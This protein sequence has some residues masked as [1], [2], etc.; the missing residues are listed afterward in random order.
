MEIEKTTIAA[1]EKRFQ[2]GDWSA[3]K[4][5]EYFLERIAN[6]DQAGAT[7][8]SVIELN[9]DAL[10]IAAELDA[11]HL[12]HGAKGSLHGIPILIKDSID[13]ADKMMTT[14]GSLAFAG[15]FAEQ[16]AFIVRKLRDAGAVLLGKTNLSEL[17]YS[18]SF[19]GCSGWSSRGGQ[20]R[21]PY[22]LD[23]TPG[24][25]SSGSAV[26]VAANLCM[27]AIGCE[28]DGSIVVPAALNSI[29]GLKPSIGL[30]SRSG[31]IP[32]SFSQDTAGPMARCVSD[33]AVL[34]NVIAA[35]DSDDTMTTESENHREEDYCKFLDAESLR[36]AR[37]GVARN[38][39]GFHEGS[40]AVIEQAISRMHE[41]GATIIPLTFDR[42]P[43][44]CSAELELILY[45]LKTYLN[46][47][48]QT[49]EKIPFNNIAELIDFNS[50]HAETI[51]PFFGQEM[52]ELAQT[53]GDLNEEA[54][55]QAKAE[56]LRISRHDGIDKAMYENQLDAIIAPTMSSP[57]GVIDQILGD[58]VLGA[59]C[60]PLPAMS[61]YP[62]ITVPAVFVHDLP[63][64][65]SFFSGAY[66][67]GKII[68]YAY[69][70]EQAVQARRQPKFLTTLL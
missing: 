34:L 23:R 50:S 40:D 14:G 17:S 45:E 41:L 68:S 43:F 59:F 21:N 64:G 66:Q 10:T 48:L 7:L 6:I 3:V 18:R 49:H 19:R 61:G 37:L 63:V 2:S 35:S 8:K 56:C 30:V 70:F 15:N 20:T 54:Y 12:N 25:S 28:T 55:L 47:Y 4:L 32:V 58:K 62:H 29:V 69:A 44:L 65:L 24:G 11:E 36:G 53:K 1:V 5:C 16:D 13:S 9:P 57:A 42:I 27:A 39:F 52:L 26:A 60:S 31:V 46:D 33:I 22:V 51:M 38:Y 67:D